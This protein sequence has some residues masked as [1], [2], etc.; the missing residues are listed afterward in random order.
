MYYEEKIVNGVLCSRT[1]SYCGW[2]QKTAEQLTEML[3]DF[4][5]QAAMHNHSNAE[6]SVNNRP[7]LGGSALNDRLAVN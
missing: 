1:N 3:A 6:L 7:S 4:K 2:V 5:R